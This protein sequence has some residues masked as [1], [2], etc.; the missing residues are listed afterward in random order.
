MEVVKVVMT[1][2]E[3]EELE[4][5]KEDSAHIVRVLRRMSLESRY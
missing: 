5:R 1:D 3:D 2:K 4:C